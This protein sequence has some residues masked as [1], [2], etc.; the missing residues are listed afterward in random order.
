MHDPHL[1]G[2]AVEAHDPHEDRLHDPLR[3][4][5]EV[6]DGEGLDR[7]RVPDHGPRVRR[8]EAGLAEHPR[9]EQDALAPVARPR[10]EA[11]LLELL[12]EPAHRLARGPR[13]LRLGP[14]AGRRDLAF[15]EVRGAELRPGPSLD[16]GRH[17]RITTTQPY[18]MRSPQAFETPVRISWGIC[19][20]PAWPVS[21]QKSSPTFI[22]IVAAIGFPT[23]RRPPDGHTGRSP[24]R[25]VTPSR[26]SLGA[27]PFGAS[28]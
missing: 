5:V 7:P 13:V 20:F 19:R 18:C 15:E 27:S 26:V 28:R 24:S 16:T 6:G 2:R 12:E 11:A 23:P 10:D 8:A 17:A 25:W 1:R 22:P 9:R 14:E 4:P 21:C 3:I